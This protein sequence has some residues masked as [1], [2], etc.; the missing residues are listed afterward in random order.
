ME[1]TQQEINRNRAIS[2]TV[3]L[4]IFILFLLFLIFFKLVTPN[5][6]FPGGGSE[7]QQL[8]LGMINVGNDV[9]DFTD[10]GKVTDVVAEEEPVKENIVTAEGGEEVAIKEQPQV[11]EDK[12]V[13]KPIPPKKEVVKEVEKKKELTEA[14][15][16]AEKYKKQTG[17]TGGGKGNNEEA[18]QEGEP[19][20]TPTGHGKGG[21][22][23]GDSNG[24][25]EGKGGPG[26]GKGPGIG[27][28]IGIDLAGRAVVKPPKLPTD[29][30]EEGKVVV[31]ITVDSQGNVIEANP[32]GRGT[33]TSSAMLKAKAK[34]AALATKFNVNGKFEEQRGTITITFSFN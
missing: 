12:V 33:T 6:P 7:G 8:A 23:D 1:L 20:G 14:Q 32:N 15:K 3:T 13:I 31:E 18:G 4:L 24:D 29:T 10:M 30:K 22:G 9:I 11:K 28:K 27:S 25:G 21:T 19:D 5:P 16:V 2:S 17:K 26:S 34:Q